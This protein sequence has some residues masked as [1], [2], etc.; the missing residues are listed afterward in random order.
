MI[1]RA[2]LY[3]SVSRS[4]SSSPDRLMGGD[5]PRLAYGRCQLAASSAPCRR[6]PAVSVSLLDA[7]L[8]LEVLQ[9]LSVAMPSMV[10]RPEAHLV[11][12]RPAAYRSAPT[13]RMKIT[14][15]C[16]PS[17]WKQGDW[18]YMT[19]GRGVAQ[20]RHG[21]LLYRSRDLKSWEYLHPLTS[22]ERN[23]K[24]TANPCDHG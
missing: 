19:V 10:R 21:F 1:F 13:P 3:V 15:F 9:F 24:K 2:L 18:Y 22:G 8:A 6:V 14:G 23:G 17:S 4:L 12:Q 16:D 5:R 20:V 11:D 7:N